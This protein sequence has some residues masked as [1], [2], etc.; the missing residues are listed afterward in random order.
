MK[1]KTDFVT[2]SSST[3]YIV[4]LPMNFETTEKELEE[5]IDWELDEV[6]EGEESYF[7]N[8]ALEGIESLQSGHTIDCEDIN[9]DSFHA[10]KYLL[11]KKGLVITHVEAGAD[12]TDSITGIKPEAIQE[13]YFSMCN[14]KE[15]KEIIDR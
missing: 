15:I 2:N 13:L 14:L 7:F 11:I 3:S 8:S 9:E 4:V 12:G 5:L 1:I 10:L 6:E